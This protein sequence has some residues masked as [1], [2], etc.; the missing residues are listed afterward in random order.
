MDLFCFQDKFVYLDEPIAVFAYNQRVA[1]ATVRFL[2]SD[3][4]F[5]DEARVS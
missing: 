5:L 4:S 1:L 3:G 2:K